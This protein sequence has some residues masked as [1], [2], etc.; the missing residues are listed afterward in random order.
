VR[1]WLPK[2]RQLGNSAHCTHN[3][4]PLQLRAFIEFRYYILRLRRIIESNERGGSV[5]SRARDGV[6]LDKENVSAREAFG[7]QQCSRLVSVVMG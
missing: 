3:N 6:A 4:V 7:L 2:Y 1:L 5:K